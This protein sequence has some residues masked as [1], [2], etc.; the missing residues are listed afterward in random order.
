MAIRGKKPTPTRLKVVRNNP[1]RRPIR[2]GEPRPA[3][4]PLTPPS[5]LSDDS[6]VEW[7]RISEHLKVLGLLTVVDRAALS[8]PIAR[9]T[10]AGRWQRGN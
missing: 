5:F 9:L 10:D 6:K 8:L 3:I 7:G 1:G 4:L 2:D